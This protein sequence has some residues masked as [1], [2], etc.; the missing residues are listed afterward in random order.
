MARPRPGYQLHRR[1]WNCHISGYLVIFS[2]WIV[3]KR[4]FLFVNPKGYVVLKLI[5]VR[6]QKKRFILVLS[7]VNKRTKKKD[8]FFFECPRK[9]NKRKY[10]L[11]KKKKESVPYTVLKIYWSV[12]LFFK[13]LE[14]QPFLC[15]L[16]SVYTVHGIN[17]W[18]N[19]TGFW[20]WFC[21][22]SCK[23]NF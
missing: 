18:S 8:L 4:S 16:S 20:N 14:Q 13:C 22:K 9:C 6:E 21:T 23:N 1:G 5:W 19:R 2:V 7:K 11:L 12:V 10:F 15:A 3:I 17:I